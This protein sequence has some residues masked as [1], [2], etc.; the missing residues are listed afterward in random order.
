MGKSVVQET[1]A[2]G[3]A[4]VTG[5]NNISDVLAVPT[6]TTVMKLTTVG[7]SAAN[8]VKTQMRT[9]GG[10]WADQTTYT[11]EQT[12][13]SVTVAAGQEW[14]VVQLVENAITDIR[15]KMSCES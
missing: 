3:Q 8:S 12:G 1:F 5:A 11:T 6:G 13:T 7:V 9:A 14:R 2:T 4:A 10:V 15:Y